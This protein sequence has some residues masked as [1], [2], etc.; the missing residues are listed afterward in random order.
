M[1]HVADE[2][3]AAERGIW[4]SRGYRQSVLPCLR[5]K[6]IVKAQSMWLIAGQ[7]LKRRGD[8][9]T[10]SVE[11]VGIGFGRLGRV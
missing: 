8:D 7:D 6:A 9:P 10:D 2:L 1:L 5:I 4:C 11:S 3:P